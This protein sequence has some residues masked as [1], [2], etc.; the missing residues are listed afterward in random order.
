MAQRELLRKRRFTENEFQRINKF[1]KRN[2]ESGIFNKVHHNNNQMSTIC[3][4][5]S[6]LVAKCGKPKPLTT[7]R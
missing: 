4:R 2:T 7:K 3:V 5:T 6:L 1:K